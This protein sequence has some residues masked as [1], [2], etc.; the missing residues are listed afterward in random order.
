MSDRL[1]ELPLAREPRAWWVAFSDRSFHVGLLAVSIAYLVLILLLVGADLAYLISDSHWGGGFS[2]N[3]ITKA[4]AQE[5]IQYSIILSMLSCTL[6]AFLAVAVAVPIGYL[7]KGRTFFGRALVD[8]ILDIPIVLPP[9]VIGLSLLI[10]FQYWPFTAPLG[11]LIPFG[12]GLINALLGF[13]G[14][15]FDVFERCKGWE[16]WSVRQLVVYQVPAVIVAQFT[17]A[18]AFAI[19]TMKATFEQIDSRQEEVAL[20]LGCSRL[21][22]FSRVVLPQV[23]PGIITAWTLAWARSL[24]EFGPLLVFAGTTRN[25]TEVLSTSVFLEISIGNLEGAVA[26]SIIMILLSIL[27]LVVTRVWG[28]MELSL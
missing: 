24:G 23:A 9:L 3:P 1:P 6:S 20:T 15:F 25:K 8:S 4:L 27:V 11:S 28:K 21:Q 26:V 2:D 16:E 19:A 14:H 22:A 18:T 13:L 10:L 12:H 5:E 17:V 7:L